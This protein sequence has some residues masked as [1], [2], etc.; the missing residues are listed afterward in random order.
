MRAEK[1]TLSS[2]VTETLKAVVSF[3]PRDP[4]ASGWVP[5]DLP[6][7]REHR[8]S[9]FS[10]LPASGSQPLTPEHHTSARS[11][12]RGMFPGSSSVSPAAAPTAPRPSKPAWCS[13]I[14]WSD[15][16]DTARLAWKEA[17]RCPCDKWP[18]PPLSAVSLSSSVRPLPHTPPPQHWSILNSLGTGSLHFLILLIRILAYLYV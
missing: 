14:A 3:V 9:L 5:P 16:E 18:L 12:L 10:A 6:R 1:A 17:D 4:A 8:C 7:G 11:A 2:S 13:L 15:A